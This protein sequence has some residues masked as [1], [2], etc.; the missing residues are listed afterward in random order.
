M[1][2]PRAMLEEE[3]K[4]DVDEDFVLPEL[5]GEQLETRTFDSTYV[6]TPDRR[7]GGARITLRRRVEQGRSVWQL[8]LPRGEGRLELEA[9]GGPVPPEELLRPLEA[10]LG[11][12]ELQPLV[13]LR[14]RRRPFC[15]RAGERELAEVVL[16][17]VSVVDGSRT[18][19]AFSEVEVER[20]EADASEMDAIVQRLQGAGARPASSST[21]LERILGPVTGDAQGSG[22]AG[23]LAAAFGKQLVALQTHDPGARVG[24]D[25]EDVHQ[26]RVATRR[27]RAYLRIARPLLDESWSEPLRAELGWLGRALGPVRDLDVLVDH[28]RSDA[29][30]LGQRDEAAAAPL[31]AALESDR[32]ALQA[33]VLEALGSDRYLALLAALEE[34]AESPH[35]RTDP[36]AP[37]FAELAAAEV[38]RL[39]KLARR[40]GPGSSDEELHVVRIR[41]KRVR[42]AAELLEAKEIVAAAKRVQDTLGEHQDAVVAEE[43]LRG[44]V[45]R[46][47][48]KVALAA[49][50]LVERQ[51]E[52]RRAARAAFPKAWRRLEAELEV[53]R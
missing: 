43:R 11:S 1:D 53:L 27:A 2:E 19:A 20:R 44:L 17:D 9:D 26:L 37:T 32:G 10:L 51:Y 48:G 33:D 14:T 50:R 35:V 23:V 34:A 8:K 41:V 3:V 49:G 22:A 47:G 42:Y 38:R 28:L 24:G 15:V 45:N 46:R 29:A 5:E 16:D 52:R 36:E 30:A 4:L 40:I 6:D 21:K 13:T 31:L 12:H 18:E 7:L 25:P 39:R